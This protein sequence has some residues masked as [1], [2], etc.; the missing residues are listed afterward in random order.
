[1][2]LGPLLRATQ[3]HN[4]RDCDVAGGDSSRSH[5]GNAATRV[6]ALLHLGCASEGALEN[7]D[8]NIAPPALAARVSRGLESTRAVKPDLG[9]EF[10]GEIESAEKIDI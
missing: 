10:D 5:T 1:M 3:R 4:T 2:W 9:S 6:K 7:G 8:V